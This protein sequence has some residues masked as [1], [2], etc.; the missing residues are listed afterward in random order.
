MTP[1]S[2]AE[3]AGLVVGDEVV[4][5]DGSPVTTVDD[6]SRASGAHS[7]GG[8]VVFTVSAAATDGGARTKRDVAVVLGERSL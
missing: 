3:A 1:G 7:V 2:P 4:A 6:V 8:T 5:V